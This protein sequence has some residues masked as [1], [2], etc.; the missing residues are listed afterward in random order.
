ME[1]QIITVEQTDI[2]LDAFL[3]RKF[4]QFS[5]SYFQNLINT[6]LVTVNN[7]PSKNKYLLQE[8]DIIELKFAESEISLLKGEDIPLK[9]IYEDKDIIVVNKPEGLVVHPACGHKTGTLVN[10]LLYKYPDLGKNNDS[11]RPG[12]VH[13]LDKGTSGVMVVAKTEPARF[14][15][16]K[17]FEKRNVQK[18]YLA[19]VYGI[20]KE[21]SGE[22]SA[23][24]G[25][26]PDNRFKM[27][28][29]TYRGRD[30]VT[31][32]KVLKRL[33]DFTYLE[34]H[35]KTGRTHQIR[36]HLTTIGHPVCGDTE[37]AY[38]VN[39]KSQEFSRM[40]LHAW[41]LRFLHPGTKKW[42]E[43]LAPVPKEFSAAL[44]KFGV[45]K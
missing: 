30:S 33:K 18:T 19:L 38:P 44:K 42:V 21:D 8:E 32:Y 41:K 12:L 9:I 16:I 27:S 35:P 20:I 17:Q 10:A 43:Y 23:P 1:K 37:Y 45:K 5:R 22:I 34:A 24:V 3:A 25:R 28:V 31:Q 29:T 40:M 14:F 36:V 13:R 15:L 6:G 39:L 2:R 11:I 26:N 7:A 4:P